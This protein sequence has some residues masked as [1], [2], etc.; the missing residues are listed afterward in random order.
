MC[1]PA[2]ACLQTGRYATEIGC[3]TNG[4]RLPQDEP[5]IAHGLSAAGYE[6]GYIGKW[7][8]ASNRSDDTN[9][10]FRTRA[11]PP[12]RRGGYED[13]WLAADVLEFTSHSYDGHMFNAD[14]SRRE[15]PAGRYRVDVLTD[16][17]IEHLQSRNGGRPFFLFVSYIEPHFQNDHACFEGPTGSKERFKDFVPP[18]DLV[19]TGGDWRKEYP[20]YLGCCASLDAS[21]GRYRAALERMGVAD[22]T[23]IVYASDHACHFCTRNSEYKRSCHDAS[24]RVPM[25]VVGP[26]FTG[27]RVVREMVSLLD[28]PPTLVA[29]AGADVPGS[30]QGRPLQ[31][32]A[33]GGAADWPQ[34]VFVQIS[35]TQIGRCIRTQKWKYSV[36]APGDPDPLE[37]PASGLYTEDFLY[38]LEADPHERNNLVDN[39][40]FAGVRAEL[41]AT[42]KR[43]MAKAGESVPEIVPHS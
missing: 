27:G 37:N 15:F 8:L 4:R 17:A 32:L 36:R 39:P 16:W 13:Y 43:R 26:G 19:G 41:R 31:P 18:G 35:E 3:H 25:V 29:A 1:G 38:D 28:L 22:N 5:T 11:V 40:A 20:D 12:E 42:L 6:A 33:S 24:I 2:R 34:D 14:G 9:E 7:H 10:H 23:L 30:M 21:V